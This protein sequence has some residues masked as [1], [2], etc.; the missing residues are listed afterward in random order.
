MFFCS[1][2]SPNLDFIGW[3][4]FVILSQLGKR[5]VS[6]AVT[7]PTL[8]LRMQV[9]PPS[10]QWVLAPPPCG[11][12]SRKPPL[13]LWTPLS[14]SCHPDKGGDGIPSGA[15]RQLQHHGEHSRLRNLPEGQLGGGAAGGDCTG[16]QRPGILWLQPQSG[17]LVGAVCLP[18]PCSTWAFGRRNELV[19][20]AI[21]S[22]GP[23]GTSSA[24]APNPSE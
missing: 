2:S 14:R 9:P 7:S 11:W 4:G 15:W 18:P 1:I 12:H 6:P 3:P 21:Q 13:G 23:L 5:I 10:R 24:M 8:H 17:I 16:R 22:A 20:P 19:R